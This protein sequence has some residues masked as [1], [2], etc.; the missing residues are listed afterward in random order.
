MDDLTDDDL[1]RDA[2]DAIVL[3]A[4]ARIGDDPRARFGFSWRRRRRLWGRRNV[5]SEG[6]GWCESG[7]PP[8]T[9]T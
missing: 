2:V 4:L 1:F 8:G 7:H 6:Y 3:N 5:A 9:T